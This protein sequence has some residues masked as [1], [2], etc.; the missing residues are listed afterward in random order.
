MSAKETASI[1]R[2]AKD[3]FKAMRWKPHAFQLEAW[4]AY[5]DGMSGLINAPT[6]SGKTYS[7]LLPI[8][9]RHRIRNPDKDKPETPGLRAIWITP[10]RA[11]AK[12]IKESAERVIEALDLDWRVEIRTGD[13]SFAARGKQKS[14][15]P[16]VLIT[17]PESL[18]LLMATKGYK[19]FFKTL[20]CIVADEWHELLG[21]KRGVQLELALS[22][23]KNISPELQ[24]W[25]I[26]ATIGNLNEA[27]EVLL[28]VEKDKPAHK[29][30]RADIRKKLE[31][32]SI[33]PDEIEHFPWSGHM[34]LK[35]LEKVLPVIYANS[36][37]LI[38]TNTRA[39]CEI[40]YQRLLETDPDL[41]GVM[42]MH[43][44]SIGKDLRSWVED[45]L[46]EERLKVVVCTSSLDLGVDFRPVEA[47]I[48]IGSP[49]GIARFLQRAGRSGHRPGAVSRIYFLPTHALELIEGAALRSAIESGIVEQRDPIVLCYDVLIQYI[50]T[51]AL[52]EGLEPELLRKEVKSTFAFQYITEEQWT[53]ALDFAVT[54]GS[55]GEYDEYKKLA[56]G[57][58]GKYR[59]VNRKM[60]MRH[61][62]SIGTIASDASLKIQFLSGKVLGTIEE[63]FIAQLKPG[64][65]FWFS[66]R[67]LELVRIKEMTAFVKASK[68]TDG[69][70]PSWLGGRMSFSS[71]MSQ[72]IREKLNLFKEGKSQD[73]EMEFLRSLFEVQQ[74]SSHLPSSD[75][76]L[77]EHF[78]SKDGYHLLMYPFEGRAVHEGMGALLAYRISQMQSITFSIGMNDYGFE[79]LSDK[80]IDI[81]K[82]INSSLFSTDNLV[83][84][85]R[86]SIN[87]VEMAERRFRD[88]ASIAGLL[89]KGFPGKEKRDRH[90]QSSAK[91]LFKVFQ[92]YEPDNLLFLQAYDEVL[93]YQLEELRL[94]E[95]LIRISRQKMILTHPTRF[96][97][98]AF[99]IV[100]DRL[101]EKMSS[102]KLEDRVARLKLQVLK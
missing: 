76:F 46:H 35:L 21:S 5:A 2:L 31:V 94:R 22:H 29:L 36:S 50:M 13:T 34:G 37:T 67:P 28:G 43:H 71:K 102:E 48:Q 99:P 69:K 89:F 61:R 38:F 25:G 93:Y 68:A 56:R 49:K 62:M 9:L 87:S 1:V 84:D 8:L 63:S 44:G 88:I 92:D 72:H 14:N 41:A 96:S 83:R 45:A 65:H 59:F 17:T 82:V 7:L 47:V 12:E 6:G 3:W 20:E 101:R 60:A 100:V 40:W 95:A 74:A 32:I 86:A 26:S 39:Q 85:I 4:K 70:I 55:L 78:K 66:G 23:L 33:M 54:G 42:A 90:L 75:E 10:I 30:I 80:E 77:I 97:P 19:D 15:P 16:E 57:K 98:F 52:G 79:M 64:D 91:L 53:R 27:M 18:H 58:D 51:M 11:L 81:D 73:V 24:I